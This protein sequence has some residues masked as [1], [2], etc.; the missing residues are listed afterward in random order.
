MSIQER[1][2]R[3]FNTYVNFYFRKQGYCRNKDVFYNLCKSVQKRK[4]KEINKIVKENHLNR[5]LIAYI[6]ENIMLSK[7][8]VIYS[9][10]NEK[11]SEALPYYYKAFIGAL[12]IVVEKSILVN[13]DLKS[14]E[15]RFDNK[16]KIFFRVRKLESGKRINEK[17]K[18]KT[19]KTYKLN[20]RDEIKKFYQKESND[21]PKYLSYYHC[22]KP[23]LDCTPHWKKINNLVSEISGIYRLKTLKKV[24]NFDRL[25]TYFNK[26]YCMHDIETYNHPY[27]KRFKFSQDLKVELP[28][29]IKKLKKIFLFGR[30][31]IPKTIID[32]IKVIQAK[33]FLEYKSKVRAEK[34]QRIKNKAKMDRVIRQLKRSNEDKALEQMRFLSDLKTFIQRGIYR[35]RERELEEKAERR[36]IFFNLMAEV[37]KL[38][39]DL[40]SKIIVDDIE[41]KIVFGNKD[42]K[43]SDEDMK[44]L[45]EH[46]YREELL[47]KNTPT[48]YINYIEKDEKQR[49]LLEEKE[50]SENLLKMQIKKEIEIT[51]NK[52][53]NELKMSIVPIVFNKKLTL[54]PKD[55]GIKSSVIKRFMGAHYKYI[56]NMVKRS[57]DHQSVMVREDCFKF[58]YKNR[59]EFELANY[60]YLLCN[61]E[62]D[63]T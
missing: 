55:W 1:I 19:I 52:L 59:K 3:R 41:K 50:T 34:R 35:R 8:D 26:I 62:L 49:K 61:N 20:N 12:N 58:L 33:K 4:H 51:S 36:N 40:E 30:Y 16:K 47:Q 5:R 53:K 24:L 7:S 17:I 48:A 9:K 10:P 25:K 29:A 44:S 11:I 45:H 38:N 54:R 42:S 21:L 57:D 15:L 60:I 37:R 31:F 13:K 2:Q 18:L 63:L 46:P 14:I 56:S 43:Y 23:N 28:I 32:D 22:G 6:Q 27:L 39:K